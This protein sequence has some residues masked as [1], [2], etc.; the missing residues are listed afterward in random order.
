MNIWT[1]CKTNLA[2]DSLCHGVRLL[3]EGYNKGAYAG[4]GIFEFEPSIYPALLP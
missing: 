4:K 2:K 1:L 3:A